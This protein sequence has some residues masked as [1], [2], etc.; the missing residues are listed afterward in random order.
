MHAVWFPDKW[1][2]LQIAGDEEYRAHGE[3]LDFGSFFPLVER[4]PPVPIPDGLSTVIKG[5]PD[6]AFLV[7]TCVSKIVQFKSK[8][9][10]LNLTKRRLYSAIDFGS[11]PCSVA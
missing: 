11:R 1:W 5:F 7:L 4:R 3:D 9:S 2:R 10:D 8:I 6:A